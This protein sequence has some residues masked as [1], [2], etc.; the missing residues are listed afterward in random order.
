M[1]RALPLA[2]VALALTG[3]RLNVPAAAPDTSTA[4]TPAA[5]TL[6]PP[7]S[8]PSG[9]RD[10]LAKLTVDDRPYSGAAYRRE[11]WPHWKD[12]DHNGCDALIA[13]SLDKPH[14]GRGCQVTAGRWSLVYVP[15]ETTDPGQVDV[16]HVVPLGNAAR[17]GGGTWSTDQRTAYANDPAVLWVVDDG[18]NQAK[19]DRSPDQ[20]RP[21]EHGVWCEY[22]HRW[23]E[24][25]TRPEYRLTATSAERDALG[26]MLD[27]CQ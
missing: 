14:V 24:V 11:D 5:V 7:V 10:E 18:A 6:L 27:T 15:G 17:S 9:A 8:R 2:A 22:A 16:D 21:A 20:W 26:E 19:G 12:P 1:N 23:I 25:K 4:P 13:A 3:C